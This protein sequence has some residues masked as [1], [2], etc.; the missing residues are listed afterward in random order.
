MLYAGLGI[1]ERAD[2]LLELGCGRPTKARQLLVAQM[3]AD[4]GRTRQD[5]RRLRWRD[6]FEELVARPSD[7]R[8]PGVVRDELRGLLCD[9]YPRTDRLLG[10][11]PRQQL[12]FTATALAA[13]TW[14]SKGRPSRRGRTTTRA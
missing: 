1:P 7:R 2:V 9:R 11:G 10:D 14:A 6:V 3:F 5:L 4:A 12:V 13:T 8:F